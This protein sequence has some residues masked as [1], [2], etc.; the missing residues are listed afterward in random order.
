MHR[1]MHARIRMHSSFSPKNEKEL[2][3]FNSQTQ[4][5]A[6]CANHYI[7]FWHS[8]IFRSILKE[9]GTYM[10]YHCMLLCVCTHANLFDVS[11]LI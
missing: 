2:Y 4:K 7:R 1:M 11:N 6:A 5:Q 3:F 10:L 8:V 9:K